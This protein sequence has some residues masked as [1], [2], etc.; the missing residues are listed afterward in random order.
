MERKL[1]TM[2]SCKATQQHQQSVKLAR[3]I[4]LIE[5]CQIKIKEERDWCEDLYGR[6]ANGRVLG[7]VQNQEYIDRFKAISFRL[8]LYYNNQI[9]KL[10][11]F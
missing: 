1:K 8:K 6:G 2:E 5:Y 3:T 10:I 11:K 4:E 9:D 7:S